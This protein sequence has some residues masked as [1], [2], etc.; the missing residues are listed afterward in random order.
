MSL[1][2]ACLYMLMYVGFAVPFAMVYFGPWKSC[3]LV[4]ETTNP[5]PSSTMIIDGYN[6]QM[7]MLEDYSE[8]QKNAIMSDYRLEEDVTAAL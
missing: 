2:N 5:Q 4:S 8:T 1:M 7:L 6:A 3:F